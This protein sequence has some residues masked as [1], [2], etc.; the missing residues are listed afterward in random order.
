MQDLIAQFSAGWQVSLPSLQNTLLYL[1]L[2]FVLS[3]PPAPV[4]YTNLALR[5]SDFE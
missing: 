1:L 4:K 3:K 2:A 5:K